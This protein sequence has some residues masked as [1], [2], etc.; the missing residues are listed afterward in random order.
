MSN[1]QFLTLEESSLVDAALLTSREKFTT[2]VAIYS[3]RSLKQ[4][5]QAQGVAIDEITPQQVLS[6]IEQDEQ[7]QREQALN[8][9][10]KQFFTQLVLSSLKP[11]QQMSENLDI[12]IAALTPRQTIA[13]FEQQS[14][15]KR[16]KTDQTP[17]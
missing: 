8:A 4:I 7:V 13:W 10:F 17:S 16:Q 12:P 3:L 5:S 9:E 1:E 6:W 14:E 11:L 2:R 15:G